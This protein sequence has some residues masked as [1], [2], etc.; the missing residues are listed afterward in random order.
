MIPRMKARDVE[1]PL[2]KTGKM[3][4]GTKL[5]KKIH[6]IVVNM[7]EAWNAWNCRLSAPGF[8][9]P[10]PAN[11]ISNVLGVSDRTVRNILTRNQPSVDYRLQKQI[12]PACK[13]PKE[14]L[15][16]REVW[17]NHAARFDPVV[18]KTIRDVINH[19]HRASTPVVVEELRQ[20]LNKQ[21]LNCKYWPTGGISETGLRKLLLGLG[22]RYRLFNIKGFR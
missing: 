17:E 6:Q 15:T 12:L 19:L 10:S 11:Y 22:Y 4:T 1:L 9:S 2:L 18:H 5:C 16:R 8:K 21:F 14:S 7:A 13:S 3:A 20:I